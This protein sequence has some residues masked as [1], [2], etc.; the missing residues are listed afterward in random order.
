MK[1]FLKASKKMRPKTGALFL[2]KNGQMASHE[3]E[4][5]CFLL[6]QKRNVASTR[7]VVQLFVVASS[8]CALRLHSVVKSSVDL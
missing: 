5:V 1:G 3:G 8:V 2:K 7:T 4:L 6:L